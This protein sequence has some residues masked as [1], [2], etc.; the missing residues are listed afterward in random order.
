MSEWES[1]T[2]RTPAKLNLGLEILGKRAD[3]YHEIRT[4][5][6]TIGLF[7]T[8]SFSR[9]ATGEVSRVLGMP[10]VD[11]QDNLI[12][13]A[14][15]AFATAAGTRMAIAVTVRKGIPSPGGIG[16]ASSDA[17][18]TLLALNT[19]SGS[20]LPQESLCTLSESL[21]ADVPFFLDGPIA[22]ARGTGTTL[23][24]LTPFHA[25]AVLVVPPLQI[26]TKT[27]T[28]YKSLRPED[29]SRG[30]RVASVVSTIDDGMLPGEE[31]LGNAFLGPLYRLAPD[32]AQLG[33]VFFRSGAPYAALSG[34]GPAHYA[35]FQTQREAREVAQ[36]IT[37]EVDTGTLVAIV[38][39]GQ[40]SIV[41]AE[42]SL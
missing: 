3:G 24:R 23:T 2:V 36:R 19:L 11:P 9:L 21:G 10:G 35:L 5:M 8:L 33:S 29:F 4:V 16:G 6:A 37:S 15:D 41:I 7:D 38:E 30:T 31:H 42:M 12:L 40:S 25:H 39:V 28:L 1:L 18:A 27:A 32:L 22:L 20:V 13:K 26:A 17:A 14:I 34:A